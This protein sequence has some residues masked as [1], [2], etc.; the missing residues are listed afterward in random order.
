MAA[1]V[2]LL[3]TETGG[4]F[5]NANGMKRNEAKAIASLRL[6]ES[7]WDPDAQ[8]FL[9]ITPLAQVVAFTN[10]PSTV[11]DDGWLRT[12]DGGLFLWIPPK[13]RR[14]LCNTGQVRVP[15]ENG[16]LMTVDR[17]KLHH[18]KNWT[19]IMRGEGVENG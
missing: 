6:G 13:H 14:S 2:A 8:R 17:R 1:A 11:P 15:N 16:Q 19:S 12:L 9:T 5:G 3:W 4:R 18:G 10:N 7:R